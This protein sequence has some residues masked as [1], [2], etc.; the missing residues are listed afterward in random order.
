MNEL[1]LH[2][3]SGLGTGMALMGD[4]KVRPFATW[5]STEWRWNGG[6]TL[7][8]SQLVE[9][10]TM[11]SGLSI[12]RTFGLP[13]ICS[14]FSTCVVVRGPKF[15]IQ[16]RRKVNNLFGPCKNI[17]STACSVRMFLAHLAEALTSPL[18]GQTFRA[19][20]T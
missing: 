12:S 17:N 4:L 14:M 11:R 2:H 20:P 19:F 8:H 10:Q 16:T 15:L 13:A 9:F 18:Q 1:R 6:S 5:Q 3:A 7:T